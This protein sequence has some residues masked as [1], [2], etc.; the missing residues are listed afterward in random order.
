MLPMSGAREVWRHQ[1]LLL[2][3]HFHQLRL[4]PLRL[5]TACLLRDPVALDN[6]FLLRVDTVALERNLPLQTHHWNHENQRKRNEWRLLYSVDLY[7][8]P[9]LQFLVDHLPRFPLAFQVQ[10]RLLLL[11]HLRLQHPLL[12]P[13][14]ICSTFHLMLQRY[15]PVLQ[16]RLL[17]MISCHLLQYWNRHHLPHQHHL[18]LLLQ[19]SLKLSIQETTNSF[20]KNLHRNLRSLLIHLLLPVCLAVWTTSHW[21]RSKYPA[22]LNTMELPWLLLPSQL[23]N[24]DNNGVP[25]LL[26]LLVL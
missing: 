4:L 15:R 1:L 9:S 7:L 17:T 2:L 12:L 18:L 10:L 26:H 24:L 23:N 11:R 22:S 8:E 6:R 3:Q 19:L 5:P 21:H 25:V 20:Q 16:H 14:L 13:K